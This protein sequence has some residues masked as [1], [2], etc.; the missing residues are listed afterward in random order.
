[1]KISV[2]RSILCQI[3]EN[4]FDNKRDII[5]IEA[6]GRLVQRQNNCMTVRR[7]LLNFWLVNLY[8]YSCT[9]RW[10]FETGEWIQLWKSFYL[11]VWKSR[12]N[13]LQSKASTKYVKHWESFISASE[14]KFCH[15]QF[16][17]IQFNAP[18][19]LR[20]FPLWRSWNTREADWK[21]SDESNKNTHN[22]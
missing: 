9:A 12:K 16:S 20:V 2:A 8:K 6:R 4:F 3:K 11:P 14:K 13:S 22:F 10:K 17:S 18:S 15:W 7:K 5:S 21:S 19:F 1:M